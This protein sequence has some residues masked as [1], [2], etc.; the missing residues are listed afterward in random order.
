MHFK[1]HGYTIVHKAVVFEIWEKYEKIQVSHFS[2][3]LHSHMNPTL[4]KIGD[5]MWDLRGHSYELGTNL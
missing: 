3:R 1:I 2:R 4:A 5:L